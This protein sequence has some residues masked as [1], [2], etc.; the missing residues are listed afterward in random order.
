MQA[1]ATIALYRLERDLDVTQVDAMRTRLARLRSDG[2]RRIVLDMAQVGYVDSAGMALIFGE[3]RRTREVGGLLSLINVGDTVASTF[4]RARLA[5]V[6][7]ICC[8]CAGRELPPLDPGTTPHWRCTIPI[9][10]G[11]LAHTRALVTHLLERT[12]LSADGRFDA[13]LAVGE[14]MGNAVDHA[15]A[16]GSLVTVAEYDDRVLMEVSDCGPGFD[17]SCIGAP[18]DACAERG[19]GIALMRLLADEVRIEHRSG[20]AGMVVRITKL[21]GRA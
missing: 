20:G 6:V 14:A 18:V 11:D 13:T 21:T 1:H 7:P 5:D 4:R 10:P 9:E 15:C 12:A 8:S 2:A 16:D 3:V 17:A 19:R